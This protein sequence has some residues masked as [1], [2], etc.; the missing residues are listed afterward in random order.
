MRTVVA[1]LSCLFAL[2]ASMTRVQADDP[3]RPNVLFLFTDD[4][5]SDTIGAFGNPQIQTPNLDALV[6]EGFV[7]RNA[8]C[9][10]GNIPAVC[11]PSRTMLLSGRS[12]FHLNRV[13]PASPS[14]P[15]SLRTAGYLTYHH[16]KRGNTPHAIHQA[17]EISKYLHDDQQERR[18]GYPGKEIADDAITFLKER[19]RSKPFFAYLAFANPHDPRVANAEDRSR[20]DEATLPLPGNYLPLHPFDNGELLIRDEAL[21]P[22]PRSPEVVK[23]HLADYYAVITHLDRQIGRIL[24]TLRQ[25]GDYEN[26]IIIFTSDHGLAIGSHGLFGKQNVYEDGMKVPLV[27]SGPGIPKGQSEAFVYLFD[28]FP[29]LCDLTGTPVPDGLDGRSVAPILKGQADKVR[30]SVFLAYRSVQRSVREGDW[31][32]IRYPRINKSQLFDLAHD[33]GETKNLA[34]DPDQAI[35]VA[36]MMDL[37]KQQQEAAGDTLPLSTPNPDPAKVDASFFN[38]AKPR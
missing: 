38:R 20:Y 16:G 6:A 18:S 22:W 7:F 27:F 14:L 29:T 12:L 32:L 35:R 9:M 23:Q 5:R 28:L 10:G 26:T 21:A 17:F 11:L 1:L 25:T 36:A 33:P 19:D 8:Y 30:D 15:K 37:L 24:D 4:Q 34:D 13:K 31:K 3:K 2:G